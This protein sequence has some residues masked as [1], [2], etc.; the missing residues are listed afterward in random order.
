M[1]I[2][3]IIVIASLVSGGIIAAS[4]FL[5]KRF[6][7]IEGLVE[8]LKS[9][10][11]PIGFLLLILGFLKIFLPEGTTSWVHPMDRQ[12]FTG[13]LFPM[14]A[15]FLLGIV[16]SA[17]FIASKLWH[18]AQSEPGLVSF[19]NTVRVGAGIGAIIIAILHNFLFDYSLF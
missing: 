18:D 4:P 15:C 17:D 9:F 2:V 14:L 10:E 19:A 6:E 13:D 8:R 12:F 16:L 5:Q 7:W 3:R 11:V 1:F